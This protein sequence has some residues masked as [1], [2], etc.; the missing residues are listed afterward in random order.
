MCNRIVG[1]VKRIHYPELEATII[2]DSKTTIGYKYPSETESAK[3]KLVHGIVKTT[4]SY[5]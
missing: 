2:T 3:T 4:R 5:F 1:T